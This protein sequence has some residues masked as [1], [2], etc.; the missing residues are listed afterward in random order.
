MTQNSRPRRA[1]T[2]IELLVVIAIIAV[3]ISLLLPAVQSAR[4]AARRAQCVNNLKQLGLSAHNFESAYNAFPRS[5]EHNATIGNVVYKSQDYH[6]TFTMILSTIEQGTVYN[7]MNIQVPYNFACNTTAGFAVV[8]TFL[9]PTNNLAGDR[10]GDGKD[11]IGFGCTDY[12]TAPYTEIMANGTTKWQAGY[13]G[14]IPEPGSLTGAQYPASVYKQYMCS[15][16]PVNKSMQLDPAKVLTGEIDVFKGGPTVGSTT[17]GTSNT[18]M[19]YE[20]TGR[21]PKMQG[22]GNYS[23]PPTD[24][25]PDLNAPAPYNSGARRSW[26]W[27]DPDNAAGVSSGINNNKTGGFGKPSCGPNDW[28]IHDCGPN[29]EI[30][31]WHPGGANMCMTDGSVRFVKDT[32][33]PAIVR[34][35]ITRAGGEVISADAY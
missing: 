29:N 30:F 33:S 17:D 25:L 32:V 34:A 8:R 9:C 13:V 15:G 18:A 2:L 35:L 31:S 23:A 16:C 5:G 26:R 12:A 7:T 4:E 19:F 14:P 10:S 28:G 3:L 1:F 27:G 11:S 20:D 21:S 24:Y 22:V 6:S